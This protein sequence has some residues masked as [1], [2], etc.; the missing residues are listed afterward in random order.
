M[1][2]GLL[3]TRYVS[4]HCSG[5]STAVDEIHNDQRTNPRTDHR[6]PLHDLD[7]SGQ[8]YLFTDLYDLA[9]VA[10]WGV[11]NLHDLGHVS[12][13]GS[14]RYRSCTTSQNGRL[15]SRPYR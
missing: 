7:I 9:H 12:W 8:I 13:V 11:Y 3:G 14:V 15:G 6:F 1:L 5:T 10:R 2:G 4:L